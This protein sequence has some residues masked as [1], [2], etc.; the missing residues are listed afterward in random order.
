MQDVHNRIFPVIW[1]PALQWAQPYGS[2]RRVGSGSDWSPVLS[3]IKAIQEYTRFFY[4]F[5]YSNLSKCLAFEAYLTVLF[6]DRIKMFWT[7]QKKILAKRISF[8]LNIYLHFATS[9]C[10]CDMPVLILPG[11]MTWIFTSCLKFMLCNSMQLKLG[12]QRATV[13][14]WNDSYVN[15]SFCTANWQMV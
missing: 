15:T 3:V 11:D 9:Y 10:N 7:S 5:N 13:S 1:S 6:F 8:L 12:W 14:G 2:C 4:F